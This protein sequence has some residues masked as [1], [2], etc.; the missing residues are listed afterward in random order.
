MSDNNGNG[1]FRTLISDHWGKALS[2]LI[3]VISTIIGI[4]MSVMEHSAKLAILEPKVAILE[5]QD[6]VQENINQNIQRDL[7]EIKGDLK[8]LLRRK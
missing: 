2:G 1:R 8:E 6:A 3:F 5:K 7:A 4:K